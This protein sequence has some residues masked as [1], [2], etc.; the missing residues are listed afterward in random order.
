MPPSS[1][2][3]EQMGVSASGRSGTA[4]KSG[5]GRKLIFWHVDVKNLKRSGLYTI[6]LRS[7]AESAVT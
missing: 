3:G 6:C 5:D 1:S 7:L 2:F 4:S